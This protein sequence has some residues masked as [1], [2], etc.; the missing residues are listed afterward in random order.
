[1]LKNDYTVVMNQKGE[2]MPSYRGDFVECRMIRKRESIVMPVDREKFKESDLPEECYA[3][4][5]GNGTV[6]NEKA[7]AVAYRDENFIFRGRIYS[8]EEM[9]ELSPNS[10]LLKDIEK[11]HCTHVMHYKG[12]WKA[13]KL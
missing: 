6:M 8:K 5:F 4:R 7:K 2:N 1:M 13:I 3:Y 10:P 9:K 12:F 11:G